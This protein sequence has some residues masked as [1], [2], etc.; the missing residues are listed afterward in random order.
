[1]I[2]KAQIKK[3]RSLHHRKG[4]KEQKQFLVEGIRAV[5]EVLKSD[6]NVTEVYIVNPNSVKETHMVA[7]RDFVSITEKQ[8]KTISALKTPP[9]IMAVVDKPAPVLKPDTNK[10]IVALDGV[11]DPG[12]FGTIMRTAHWF[13]IDQ[14]FCSTDC[15]DVYN[16]KTVQ[17]SMGSVGFVKVISGELPDF[18]RAYNNHY[19]FAGMQMSGKDIRKVQTDKKKIAMIIG[20]EAFGI[21]NEVS[22]LMD[23]AVYIM[24]HDNKNKPESLNASIAA[25]IGMFHFT[26]QK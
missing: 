2:S 25:A 13:G 21:S 11:K 18:I 19:F 7:Y 15:V 16:P 3:I 5:E 1:M 8:M 4:R 12:N 14:I 10:H 24:P 20:N 22:E 9:G 23:D 6:L 26:K 17:S